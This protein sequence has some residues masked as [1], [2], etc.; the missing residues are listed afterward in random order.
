MCFLKLRK[1]KPAETEYRWE[2]LALWT[3]R[4][5]RAKNKT[6]LSSL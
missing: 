5:Y 6:Y 1:K 4:N 2:V 3:S